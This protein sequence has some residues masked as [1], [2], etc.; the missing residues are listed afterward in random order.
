[1]GMSFSW[2]PFGS[3]NYPYTISQP[4]SFEYI[5][6]PDTTGHKRDYFFPALGSF[7]TYVSVYAE[8]GQRAPNDV[9]HIRSQGGK[10]VRPVGKVVIFGHSRQIVQGDFT[11]PMGDWTIQQIVFVS[12]HHVWYLTMSYD[13]KYQKLRPTM[14]K[15]LRTFRVRSA[16]R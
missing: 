16:A 8:G 5:A 15:M 9:D 10:H 12:R 1:M 6:L 4:A 2:K 3:S 13:P 14:L 11:G 7:T